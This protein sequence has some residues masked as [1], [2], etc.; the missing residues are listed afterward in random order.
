MKTY[1]DTE[2]IKAAK[3]LQ[4]LGDVR[5]II[6]QEF[7]INSVDAEDRKATLHY[8]G[9]VE[10]VD[11]QLD[12]AV[13]KAKSFGNEYYATMAGQQYKDKDYNKV[14]IWLHS[15]TK[16]DTEEAKNGT[17][18]LLPEQWRIVHKDVMK[19]FFKDFRIEKQQSKWWPEQFVEFRYLGHGSF[20]NVSS[21]FGLILLEYD[22]ALKDFKK[23]FNDYQFHI[24]IG[25]SNDATRLA[26]GYYLRDSESDRDQMLNAAFKATLP[27]A[28]NG[29]CNII[30][31]YGG[32]DDYYYVEGTYE[33]ILEICKGMKDRLFEYY[34]GII[35]SAGGNPNWR[36]ATE[37]GE[38]GPVYPAESDDAVKVKKLQDAKE[39][40]AKQRSIAR[41]AKVAKQIYGVD[42]NTFF[43]DSTVECQGYQYSDTVVIK[44]P[45][46]FPKVSGSKVVMQDKVLEISLYRD[47]YPYYNGSDSR[48]NE[49]TITYHVPGIY[50]TMRGEF[51]DFSQA[52]KN[53]SEK[54]MTLKPTRKTFRDFVSERYG[55][56]SDSCFPRIQKSIDDLAAYIKYKGY[57]P[58]EHK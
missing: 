2:L 48:Y 57:L 14:N 53:D 8:I 17:L 42:I 56:R 15:I 11:A 7:T 40:A 6:E 5:P 20:H 21:E 28:K 23:S 36:T 55:K 31:H 19:K 47:D 46:K 9:T 49:L 10:G 34:D 35:K 38:H 12:V 16:L 54:L 44:V 33:E 41:V 27:M 39:S 18:K 22:P 32:Y 52:V 43:K 4:E 24:D 45:Y 13:Y 58:K 37:W 51:T 30:Q 29:A 50:G 3:Y 25:M 26:V 1:K